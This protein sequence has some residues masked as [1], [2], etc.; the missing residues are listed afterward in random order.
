MTLGRSSPGLGDRPGCI[1]LVGNAGLEFRKACWAQI[2][3]ALLGEN[4]VG[5]DPE[6]AI[7]EGGTQRSLAAF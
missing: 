6:V 5:S 4:R 2:I 3:S 7:P 1:V